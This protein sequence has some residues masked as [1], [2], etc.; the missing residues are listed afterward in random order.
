MNKKIVSIIL[1][2]FIIGIFTGC[3]LSVE[4]DKPSTYKVKRQFL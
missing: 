1:V 2:C 4:Q 3:D